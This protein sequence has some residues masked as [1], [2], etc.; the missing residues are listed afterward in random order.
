MLRKLTIAITLTGLMAGAAYAGLAPR[1]GINGSKHDMNTLAG[2]TQDELARTCV[3][4]HTPHNATLNM[5]GPLWNRNPI[6]VGPAAYQWKTP[7]NADLI[8]PDDPAVGPTRLCL[9]CHDGSIAAD[10]HNSNRHQTGTKKLSGT[11]KIDTFTSHPIGFDYEAAVALRGTD[12]LVPS[13]TPFLDSVPA[14]F[15]THN[16]GAAG[17]GKKISETLYA[18]GFMTCASCHE[19][20]NRTNYKTTATGAGAYNYF[21]HAAQEGSALCLSC[22]IK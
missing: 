17:T 12:E 22:H 5:D 3:F 14:N 13:S 15:D 16:R 1:T 6:S 7:A 4:C 2:A 19:V 21:L 18:G 11:A 8:I 10:S 20:H 9:S